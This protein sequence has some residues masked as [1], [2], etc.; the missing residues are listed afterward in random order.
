MDDDERELKEEDRIKW[1]RNLKPI[2]KKHP[3][4]ELAYDMMLGI[5]TVVG[6]VEA[7][8]PELENSFSMVTDNNRRKKA[9]IFASGYKDDFYG[10]VAP[11]KF[12]EVHSYKFPK[13][14][15]K[16]TPSHCMKSFKFKD[17]CPQIFK[18]L[19]QMFN[20]DPVDYQMEV[21]GNF[22]YL[23]FMS[24]SK[25]GQFFFY[26]HNQKYMVKTMS[27]TEAKLLRKIL[28][29][30][31]KYIKKH[32]HSLLVKYFGMHRVKPHRRDRIYFLI[33][34]SVF[35]S[36]E[37]ME[38]HEQYDL[39]GSTKGRKSCP[40]ESMKKDLDF[41]EKEKEIHIGR[42]K[43]K[44]LK[45]QIKLDTEFLRK[46]GIMDYSLLVGIHY[47]DRVWGPPGNSQSNNEERKE[48]LSDDDQPV[49]EPFRR[50]L[51]FQENARS[52]TM[53]ATRIVRDQSSRE[54]SRRRKTYGSGENA[55]PARNVRRNSFSANHKIHYK[56]SSP[57]TKQFLVPPINPISQEEQDRMRDEDEEL[58][59]D[60]DQKLNP[61]T[62]THGGMC[63]KDPRTG[64]TG[65]EIYYTGIIDLLQ[66]YN[67]RKKMENFLKSR[68]NDEITISAVD[69]EIYS[70]RF[71]N[72]MDTKIM[73]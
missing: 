21:C 51:T 44:M 65:N 20:I 71:N 56:L 14:G 6:R 70:R 39:K 66:R 5:R 3:E 67:R 10:Q 42:K 53:P 19:R 18:M 40:T 36:E 17:Y 35:Y 52:L 37:N 16:Y 22:H 38:I 49:M 63:F 23:E 9:D 32:P 59:D 58:Y 41:I 2:A 31:Y 73:T 57:L 27:K 28:P 60:Y 15:G 46:L 47:R 13:Q 30:Y 24:N 1:R 43:A 48:R 7:K 26:S 61:F 8:L 45:Q 11:G 25:S 34:G 29:Q 33:M 64:K 12:S 4:F 50:S 68:V 55:N 69:P 72:F 54:E 62:D